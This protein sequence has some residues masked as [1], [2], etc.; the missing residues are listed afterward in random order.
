[1]T[2]QH[3]KKCVEC[4]REFGANAVF[5]PYD[6]QALAQVADSASAGGKANVSGLHPGR[7]IDERYEIIEPIGYGGMGIVF[8]ALHVE[9]NR[10]VALKILSP[11]LVSDPTALGRFRREA[12]ALGAISHPNAVSVMDF[13]VTE[14]GLAFLVM[15]LLE[16]RTLR[17][18]LNQSAIP[19]HRAARIL[20]QVCGAVEEA[21]RCG[22]I[23]RDLKPDNIMLVGPEGEA[24][25]AKVL[26]FGIAKLRST[27][28]VSARLTAHDTVVGTPHYM[29]PEACEHG[30]FTP[31]SDVYALAIILYEM[32]AGVAPFDGANALDVAVRQVN[33]PPP[34]LRKYFPDVAPSVEGVVMRSLSK[35]PK[36]RHASA[37]ELAEQFAA[38]IRECS[39]Q[40]ARI[41]TDLARATSAFAA[42]AFAAPEAGN[43]IA[44]LASSGGSIRSFHIPRSVVLG[45][46]VAGGLVGIS[47]VL[48]I[49]NALLTHPDAPPTRREFNIELPQPAPPSSHFGIRAV[50]WIATHLRSPAQLL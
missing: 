37:V 13:G 35:K 8:R 19:P 2:P 9:L 3:V 20:S 7:V 45:L 22:V 24:E 30:E 23:H 26:D 50:P 46:L 41:T 29:A 34:P 49:A 17:D 4:G 28:R 42:P 12:R 38:A 47:L 39:Q 40:S 21:H 33:D 15:E 36:D 18:I 25:T 1:M 14:D 5:C 27:S 10:R 16:G 11:E 32:I 6:G 48:F 44:T 31:A 43:G